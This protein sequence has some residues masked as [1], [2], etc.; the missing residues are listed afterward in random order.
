MDMM[1]RVSGHSDGRRGLKVKAQAIALGQTD[2][3]GRRGRRGWEDLVEDR[4]RRVNYTSNLM[5]LAA[6]NNPS[7][8]FAA[9]RERKTFGPFRRYPGGASEEICVFFFLLL[10]FFAP[11]AA[12]SRSSGRLREKR[13]VRESKIKRRNSSASVSAVGPLPS[14][15]FPVELLLLLYC[16]SFTYL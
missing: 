16:A 7:D 15:L 5:R 9:F 1:S 2:R 4:R 3:Q 8:S 11:S 12:L 14:S 6:A 13:T 10:L